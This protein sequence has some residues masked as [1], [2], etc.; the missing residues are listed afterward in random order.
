MPA[1]KR[2]SITLPENLGT[3]VEAAK[4]AYRGG[5]SGVIADAL[6]KHQAIGTAPTGGTTSP[7]PADM[8]ELISIV[9]QLRN[10]G[11]ERE[12]RIDLR[13]AELADIIMEVL[14]RL[15]PDEQPSSQPSQV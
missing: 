3:Y 9:R 1:F 15:A 7:A 14:A 10:D 8:A 11:A 6:T 2:Y 13:I 4:A 5:V 12:N